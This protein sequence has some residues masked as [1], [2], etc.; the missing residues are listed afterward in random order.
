MM[1]SCPAKSKKDFRSYSDLFFDLLTTESF[2]SA[3]RQRCQ[4]QGGQDVKQNRITRGG[5]VKIG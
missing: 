5:G 3:V 4:G 1:A 2:C